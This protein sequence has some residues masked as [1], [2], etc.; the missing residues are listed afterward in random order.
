MRE[1]KGNC[2]AGGSSIHTA[3]T[4]SHWTQI[5]G[6]HKW[7]AKCR[8]CWC[9]PATSWCLWKLSG[10]KSSSMTGNEAFLSQRSRKV[11]E[12]DHWYAAFLPL[13]LCSQY[14]PI[15]RCFSLEIWGRI[16]R[17]KIKRKCNYSDVTDTSSA[18]SKER[19]SFFFQR[20]WAIL[21][22]C[23]LQYSSQVSQKRKAIFQNLIKIV[24][25][26]KWGLCTSVVR[27][28]VG[29]LSLEH[30]RIGWMKLQAT[31]SSGRSPCQ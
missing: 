31:W 18:R 7:Y 17:A 9:I 22:L 27:E 24:F 3:K 11:T 10:L 14:K 28:A 30:S 23:S 21:Q 13:V 6:N 29:A 1:G 19:W 8:L 20:F 25:F 26:C 16:C 12:N 5:T 2:G 15:W 4:E